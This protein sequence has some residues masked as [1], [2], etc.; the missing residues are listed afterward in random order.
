MR[1]VLH[2]DSTYKLDTKE[3]K[4]KVTDWRPSFPRASYVI[5]CESKVRLILTALNDGFQTRFPLELL[6][7]KVPPVFV[8]RSALRRLQKEH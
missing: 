4:N 5:E 6:F 2:D 8:E 3:E 7:E 1:A